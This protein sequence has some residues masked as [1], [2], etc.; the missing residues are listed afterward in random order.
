MNVIDIGTVLNR[1]D[2]TYDE[3][4]NLVK[5]FCIKFITE[6]GRVRSMHCRKGV[7]A[8]KQQLKNGNQDRGKFR[9]NLKRNGSILLHDIDINESRSPKVAMIFMFKDFNSTE[10]LKVFH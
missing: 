9:F 4:N 2:D 7:K 3:Q 8:P 1:F 6:D 10:W 5:S